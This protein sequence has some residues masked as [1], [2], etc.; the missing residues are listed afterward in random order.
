MGYLRPQKKTAAFALL[1]VLVVTVSDLIRPILVGRAMDSI[2]A[3][4]TFSLIVRYSAVYLVIL[5]LGTICSAAQMWILQKLG[6]DIIYQVRQE[7]FAH[8]HNLSLRFFDITPVGRIVTRV[9][10]DVETLNELFS[11][12]LV[13][14]VKN[15]V[16]ILGYAGV[17]LYLQWKL[18]LVSFVLLPLVVYLSPAVHP[19]V[20]D[21]PPDHPHKGL[22]HEYL[23]L[24][25][26][27]CHEADPD[28]PPGE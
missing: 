9:T 7:L 10:N 20:P 25:K 17:M 23:P 8:I 5:V 2:T 11:S 4:G 14:M 3:G 15:A 24:G 1:L 21:H 12:I 27:V 16:L 28:L 6:Q 26:S 19:A 13:T 18:A 22:R